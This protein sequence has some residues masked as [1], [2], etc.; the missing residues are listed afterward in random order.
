MNTH[1]NPRALKALIYSAIFSGMAFFTSCSKNTAAEQS[2][3]SD[4][5][6]EVMTNDVTP[7]N[8]GIVAE[9]ESNT[10][11]T[12]DSV[13]VVNKTFT[14][15]GIFISQTGRRLT[16]TREAIVKAIDVVIDKTTKKIISGSA[17]L[18]VKGTNSAGRSFYYTG[19]LTFEGNGKGTLVLKNGQTFYLHW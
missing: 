6:A 7:A 3:T 11:V 9:I 19:S 18:I 17:E 14:R 1:A 10:S 13:F 2:I 4:E 8:G 16:I 15:T 5:A 12:A